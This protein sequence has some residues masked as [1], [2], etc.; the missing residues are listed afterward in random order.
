MV[1]YFVIL[2]NYAVGPHILPPLQAH[3]LREEQLYNES[4]IRARNVVER[5]YG[6]WKARFPILSLGIQLSNL[7]QN[8]IVACAVLQNVAR[9]NNEDVPP[10]E[11]QIEQQL[12]EYLHEE[13]VET[14]M[15][16]A[17]NAPNPVRENTR[18]MF[19]E[20]FRN[21]LEVPRM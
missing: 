12:N 5:F 16:Q 4:Q 7:I 14:Q 2:H 11:G 17:N 10:L 6:V 21:R 3:Q 20:Y 9:K 1:W 8:I 19:I 13:T 15:E 18:R